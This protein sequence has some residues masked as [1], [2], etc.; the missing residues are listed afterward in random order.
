MFGLDR[1]RWR[2][3]RKSA[4][5]L[6][7][8]D[9]QMPELDGFG[10]LEAIRIEPMPVIVFVTAH[11]Q[12]LC[13]RSR[14]IAVDYLLKPFDRERFGTALNHA[15]EQVKQRSRGEITEKQNAVLTELKP[16]KPV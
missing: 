7:F 1:K 10:V 16:P 11:D 2:H 6:I 13:A 3:L 4:S 12:L 15:L 9:I 8:L 5:D 14:F